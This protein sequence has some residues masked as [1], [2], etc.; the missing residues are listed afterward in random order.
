ML[1]HPVAD[2]NVLRSWPLQYASDCD[3]LDSAIGPLTIQNYTPSF[4]VTTPP[5]LGTGG[6]IFGKFIVMLDLVLVWGG[7]T[8]GTGSDNGNGNYH[9][10]VPIPPKDN[11]DSVNSSI[12]GL[13]PMVGTAL[14]TDVSQDDPHTGICSLTVVSNTPT[15]SFGNNKGSSAFGWGSGAPFAWTDGDSASFSAMYFINKSFSP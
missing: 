10:T 12:M 5:V 4:I 14:A 9:I 1:A 6:V 13:M 2:L 15:F 11:L 3:Q 8:F 7:W